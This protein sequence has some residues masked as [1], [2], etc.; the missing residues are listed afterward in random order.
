VPTTSNPPHTLDSLLRVVEAYEA[1]VAL[2]KLMIDKLK[3]QVLRRD[4]ARFGA[5]SEQLNSP[6]IALIEGQPLDE[7][8]ASRT[9]PK[10]NAA[11]T[12]EPDRKL[13][14]H[15]PRDTKTYR[16][17]TTPAH[18]DANGQQCGCIACGGRLRLIGQDVSEQLEYVPAHFKAI[19]HVRPKL[20][21]VACET[22]FQAAAPSRPIAR[23]VA[24]PGLLAHVMVS[25][26]CDHS[27]PRARPPP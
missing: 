2:L 8:L 1:E 25:K 4:R 5:S 19:R 3:L 23:G 20:A 15:L 17:E 27:V 18:H 9:P 22:I 12:P 10:K 26:Y 16:P 21:C 13:P 6:Q 24:G 14:A 11:N 7:L